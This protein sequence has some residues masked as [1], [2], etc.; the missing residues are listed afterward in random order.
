MCKNFL[1]FV[2]WMQFMILI[3]PCFPDFFILHSY[4]DIGSPST[5]VC[6]TF[7][8]SHFILK[9]CVLLS[10]SF[11]SLLQVP[12]YLEGAKLIEQRL[13]EEDSKEVLSLFTSFHDIHVLTLFIFLKLILSPL[14]YKCRTLTHNKA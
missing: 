4:V 12:P 3:K 1:K 2:S 5:K 7:S 11:H 13:L 14:V 9:L 6:L 10:F 8:F